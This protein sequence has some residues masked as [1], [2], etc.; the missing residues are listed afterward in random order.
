MRFIVDNIIHHSFSNHFGLTQ[1]TFYF[2]ILFR[3]IYAAYNVRPCQSICTAV[4]DYLVKFL[5]FVVVY[6]ACIF[7]FLLLHVSFAIDV[8]EAPLNFFDIR[9][10]Q[11]AN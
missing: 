9:N 6:D 8:H 10:L 4:F 2:V 11:L 7:V 5:I 1:N 3:F